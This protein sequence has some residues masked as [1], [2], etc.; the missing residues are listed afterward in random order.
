MYQVN[1]QLKKLIT[2]QQCLSLTF[3]CIQCHSSLQ[4]LLM[5]HYSTVQSSDCMETPK[6]LA[7]LRR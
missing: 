3:N 4:Q 5:K 1:L 6:R 7:H 2:F